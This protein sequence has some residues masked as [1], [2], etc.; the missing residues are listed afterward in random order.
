MPNKLGPRIVI[1]TLAA[2]LG[3]PVCAETAPA[4]GA[5]PPPSPPSESELPE[6]RSRA[7][8]TDSFRPSEEVSEDFA[9]PFPAD[10]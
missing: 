8:P 10:I 6:Y 3:A 7:L 1:L 9:V 5:P 2:M 4:E